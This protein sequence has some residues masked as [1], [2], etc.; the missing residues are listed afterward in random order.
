MRVVIAGAGHAGLSV[1]A[2]LQRSGHDV[3]VI[4]RDELS[5]RHA[6][7]Q[8]GLVALAGDATSAR[9]L[10]DADVPHADVVVAMLRRDA[11][12]LA[13]AL[14]AR[15]AGVRRV[16]VRMRDTEY[17]SVYLAAG[18]HRILSETD[19]LI[20]AFSTAIEHE[21]VRH[22]MVLGAG[23]SIAVEIV[24]P[25][26]ARVVGRTVREIAADPGFPTSCVFAGLSAT[27]AVE[28]PRGSSVIT[29]G[30][31]LLLVVRQRDL[32]MTIKFFMGSDG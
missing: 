15:E 26:E 12:N 16:M 7:E 17:R 2:H 11:D 13:V 5:A 29:A 24:V 27:G 30:M 25:E 20:G 1:A 3:T 22:S 8:H 9:V 28:V 4:D 18:V 32:S 23:E 31:A 14:L 6:M 10:R 19:V 21:A